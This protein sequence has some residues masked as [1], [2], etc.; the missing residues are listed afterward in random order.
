MKLP[1]L[2]IASCSSGRGK[3]VLSSAL[4]YRFRDIVRAF[5]IGPDFIDP[6]FHARLCGRASVNLD[7]FIMN[8]EQLKR[9]FVDNSAKLNLIEGAMGFYDGEDRGCSTHS[10]TAAL[11]VPVVLL[12]DAS[13][14]YITLSALLKGMREYRRGNMIKAVVLNRVSSASH[15][16]RIASILA[17]EH[18]DIELLGWIGRELPSLHSTHLG[19]DMGDISLMQ[20]IASQ[21][22]EHID[23]DA[24]LSIAKSA[25]IAEPETQNPFPAH[26]IGGKKAVLVHDENFSFLYHDNYLFLKESFGEVQIVSAVKDEEIDPRSDLVLL[27]GGY[28][29][30]EEAYARIAG[31]KRF[32]DS[33]RS[34]LQGGGRVYAE[35]AG[36]LYLSERVDDKRMSGILPLAFHME[37]RFQRL[38]Y[39]YDESGTKGHAFHY[40]RPDEASLCKAC[41]RLSKEPRGEGSGG[42]WCAYEGR[43]RATYLHTM[44][45]AY[46]DILSTERR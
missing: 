9:L 2:C 21:V 25:Q 36:L 24:L 13:G 46:P 29:E 35:C 32:A 1:S 17:R 28:V 26:D 38:G 30:S 45:R 23:M 40:P 44:F 22:L 27:C 8:E 42:V 5:K 41:G 12:M 20:S 7:S 14:S 43:L 4:M 31:S 18:P 11:R 16:E 19:L 15:Y 39:Y 33:L 6:R 37:K 3:T 34:Y 10:V